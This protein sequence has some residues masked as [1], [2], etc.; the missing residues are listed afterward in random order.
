M[1]SA[2]RVTSRSTTHLVAETN[3]YSPGTT[4][5][6]GYPCST[7]SGSPFMP[8]ASMASRSS[9]RTSNGVDALKP[10]MDVESTMSAPSFGLALARTSRMGRPSHLAFPA[11]FPPTGFDTQVRVT[12][13]SIRSASRRSWKVRVTSSSTIPCTRSSQSLML[14]SGTLRAVSMR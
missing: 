9:W 4:I 11:N 3:P 8:M 13:D 10:S 6:T 1:L 5:R 12:C 14:I 2:K 7:G